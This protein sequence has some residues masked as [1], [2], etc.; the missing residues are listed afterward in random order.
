M[1]RLEIKATENFNEMTGRFVKTEATTLELEH[2]L[3]C[4]NGRQS[5]RSPS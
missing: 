4:Q 3:Q 5:I 2:S 1:L